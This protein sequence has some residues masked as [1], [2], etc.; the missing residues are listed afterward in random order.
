[1]I[2]NAMTLVLVLFLPALTIAGELERGIEASNK[3][4]Y[5]IAIVWFN[6]HIREHPKDAVAYYYRGNAYFHKQEYDKAIEDYSEAIRLDPKLAVAY[7]YRGFVYFDKQEYDKAIEDSTEAIRLDP[8]LAVAYTIRGDAYREKKE[9][10]KAIEDY[11]EA[12]RLDPKLAVAYHNR[13]LAYFDKQEYD[14]A[15]EGFTEAIR[16][17]PKVAV[18]YTNRGFVYFDKQEYDKA[19]ED[20]TEVIRLDPKDA[21]AYYNRGLCYEQTNKFYTALAD[22]AEAG[23]LDPTSDGARNQAKNLTQTIRK[24]WWSSPKV[25]VLSMNLDEELKKVVTK[26]GPIICLPLNTEKLVEDTVTIRHSTT[27]TDGWKAEP[28]VR[29]KVSAWWVEVEAALK[30]GIERS[31]SKTYGVE[32]ETKRSVTIKGTDSTSGFRVVWVEYYRTGKAKVRI[33][34]QEV[35]LP[36]EFRE[37]FDLLT[38][39]AN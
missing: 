37:D 32:T 1:M 3:K 7:H 15:I 5:D 27:V 13:G 20:I 38:E 9:Y 4:D 23:R 8:K 19:I 25:T 6:A 22:Y 12:I 35:E 30:D 33:D 16:L 2:R 26:K 28:E 11:T 24:K 36:F 14:K 17:D 21:V 10:D 39:K 31:T 18:A 29:G 34:N